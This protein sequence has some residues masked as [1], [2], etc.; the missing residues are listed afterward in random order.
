MKKKALLH[1]NVLSLTL[2]STMTMAA[3]VHS[4]TNPHSAAPFI[5]AHL[6][7]TE[8]SVECMAVDDSKENTWNIGEFCFT[9][10]IHLPK[11][12]FSR[13][14]TPTRSA[15]FKV[16]LNPIN[17][18]S[19]AECIS[20]RNTSAKNEKTGGFCLAS[21]INTSLS[22]I[23]NF[24]V[25]NELPVTGMQFMQVVFKDG[26]TL[27]SKVQIGAECSSAGGSTSTPEST[28]SFCMASDLSRSTTAFANFAVANGIP[29]VGLQFLQVM[30]EEGETSNT[31]GTR[32]QCG[33][34]GGSTAETGNT[35]GFCLAS[36]L[37]TS[38]AGFTS[39][40]MAHD[41]PVSDL[42]FLQVTFEDVRSYD[43]HLSSSDQGTQVGAE[44]ISV[45][46]S[47]ASIGNP[48]AFCLASDLIE[49]V[50]NSADIAITNDLPVSGMQYL[51]IKFAD[52]DSI[53]HL[54]FPSID[55]KCISGDGSN[56][57]ASNPTGFCLVSDLINSTTESANISIANDLPITALE[58]LQVPSKNTPPFVGTNNSQGAKMPEGMFI[59]GFKKFPFNAI[60]GKLSNLKLSSQRRKN[61]TPFFHLS[62]KTKG[63]EINSIPYWQTYPHLGLSLGR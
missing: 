39:F 46:G 61:Q 50:I 41:I 34:M 22:G 62:N 57:T 29:V 30:F 13:P 32:T 43:A 8:E 45:D 49:S 12:N 25:A 55:A 4:N 56:A 47:S 31:P 54:S 20:S 19:G 51:Q 48:K 33:S 18:T 15:K 14:V 16:L 5:D 38:T 21:D 44:C 53:N 2:F 35:G 7:S 59:S 63:I 27:D 17:R 52:G 60:P 42:Q 3:E 11:T 28:D 1:Y 26:S 9:S 10:N 36:N 58:F 24:S 23:A 6:A 37:S 40:S